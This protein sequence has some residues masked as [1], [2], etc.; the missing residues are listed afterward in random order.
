MAK[1]A[2]TADAG[3]TILRPAGNL[4]DRFP[5]ALLAGRAAER[6]PSESFESP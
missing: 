4:L 1:K 2:G 6:A 3:T 5:S